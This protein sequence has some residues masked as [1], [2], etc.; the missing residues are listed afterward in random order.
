MVEATTKVDSDT[1]LEWIQVKKTFGEIGELPETTKEK[2]IRKMKENPLVPI[3]CLATAGA[4]TFGL[5]SFRKGDRR[6]SQVMMR[7]RI[8]AQGFTVLALIGGVAF[9]YSK[10]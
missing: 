5:Y 4:L 6:M 9:S 10:K 2:M 1:D 3:G 7:T 8:L